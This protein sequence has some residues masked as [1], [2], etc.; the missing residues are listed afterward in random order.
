MK[1][2]MSCALLTIGITGFSQ[3]LDNDTFLA[4][5]NLSPGYNAP[6]KIAVRSSWSLDT[7]GTF[8]YWMPMEENLEPG[9]LLNTSSSTLTKGEV[10]DF[11]FS[12]TPAFKLGLG[13]GM[14]E[15]QWVFMME[16]TRL[17]SS[18][19]TSPNVPAGDAISPILLMPQ[20]TG[21]NNYNSVQQRW[22]LTFD[23]VDACLSRS[24]FNGTQ[25]SFCYFFGVRGAWIYQSLVNQFGS[26]GNTVRGISTSMGIIDSTLKSDSWA[27]G[28]RVG[29][30]GNWHLGKGARIY[31]NGAADLLF[32]R[33]KISREESSTF[34]GLTYDVNQRQINTLR[35]H[36]DLELGLGWGSHFG[37]KRWHIDFSAGYGF[38]A[39]FDQNMFRAFYATGSS[40][41]EA[42]HGNLYVQG[43]SAKA[44]LDF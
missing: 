40:V 27:V 39:F 11:S 8:L 10:V 26:I 21:S 33:Y 9:I 14:E 13:F 5:S 12:F 35:A 22:H 1:S 20:I 29:L 19:K 31:G 34:L 23:F 41:G 38:Q 15:D 18:M 28:P 6:D 24:Y 42:P 30:N 37:D 32:T 25:L 4:E 2:F 16:Y 43:L 7:T 17:R 44:Q 36:I 3:G